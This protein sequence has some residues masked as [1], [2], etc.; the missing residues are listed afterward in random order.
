VLPGARIGQIVMIVVAV[1]VILGLVL[2]TFSL[3]S[4]F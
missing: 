2:S 1:I 3:P 4:G